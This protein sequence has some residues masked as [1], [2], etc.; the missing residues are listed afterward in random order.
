MLGQ[1]TL[2]C[3]AI[4]VGAAIFVT[5]AEQP[6][7]FAL[8]DR[9]ALVE[10]QASYRRAAPMQAGLAL[11]TGLVWMSIA[12]PSLPAMPWESRGGGSRCEERDRRGWISFENGFQRRHGVAVSRES[13]DVDYSQPG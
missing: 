10:W 6:A 2:I 11:V 7:R 3:A 1:I 4:F 12:P 5:V 9:A 8:S 13:E